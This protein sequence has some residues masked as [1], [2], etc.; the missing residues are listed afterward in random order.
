MMWKQAEY[1][2]VENMPHVESIF[3]EIHGSEFKPDP[4]EIASQAAKICKPHSVFFFGICKHAFDGFLAAFIKL[5]QVRSV[6]VVLD[7]LKVVCPDML[8]NS[9]DAISVFRTLEF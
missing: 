6:P 7:K 3:F 5:A 9:F 4:A 8:F 1:E 2:I